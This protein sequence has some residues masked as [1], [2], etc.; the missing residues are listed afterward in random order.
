[1]HLKDYQEGGSAVKKK[2]FHVP[3][4][5]IDDFSQKCPNVQS[6]A[7]KTI[8]FGIC[9]AL[10]SKVLALISNCKCIA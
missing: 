2:D 3:L 8:H 6:T 1:M 4:H 10:I 5:V 7:H 9:T